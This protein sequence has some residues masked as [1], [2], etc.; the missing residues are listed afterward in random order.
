MERKGAWLFSV[1]GHNAHE[2]PMVGSFVFKDM[3]FYELR[4]ELMQRLRVEPEPKID[5]ND[6][7]AFY[8]GFMDSLKFG[9][10]VVEV[11]VEDPNVIDLGPNDYRV[12]NDPP[13]ISD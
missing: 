4:E 11:V 8:Q 6:F 12:V 3:N 13:L 10:G 7:N 5:F 1:D 2:E 9:T